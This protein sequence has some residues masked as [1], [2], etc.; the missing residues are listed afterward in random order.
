MTGP[1]PSQQAAFVLAYE[2][3]STNLDKLIDTHRC[4]RKNRS[5]RE[6]ETMLLFAKLGDHGTSE[7]LAQLLAV[8]VDRLARTQATPAEPKEI[9]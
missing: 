2:Y 3:A 1:S 8:A 6:A 7:S 4:A 9:S 5:N